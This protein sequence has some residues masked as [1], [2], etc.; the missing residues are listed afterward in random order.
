M[1][2]LIIIAHGSK[3]LLSNVEF[4][5]FVNEISDENKD[6]NLTIPAFLELAEP[7][8]HEAV[9]YALHKNTNEIYFYPYF[10]NSGKHIQIDIPN[11]V[12]GLKILYPDIKLELL[13]HF[14]KSKEIK[15]IVLKD[16]GLKD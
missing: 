4:I 5:E 11:I 13:N 15:N 16:V 14:G 7:S 9:K 6:Y 12:K 10:L 2:T 1:K 3:K 8:I